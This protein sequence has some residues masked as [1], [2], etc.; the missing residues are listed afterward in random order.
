MP[1]GDVRREQHISAVSAES[2]A[3]VHILHIEEVA[4]VEAADG[5]EIRTPH[6]HAGAA[7]ARDRLEPGWQRRASQVVARSRKDQAEPEPP[8]DRGERGQFHLAATGLLPPLAIKHARADEEWCAPSRGMGQETRQAI[9]RKDAVRVDEQQELTARLQGTEVARR[10]EADV[11][12][13][14]QHA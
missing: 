1:E 8:A 12:V 6:E 5:P 7:G 2:Q 11:A 4:L 10:A 14:G 13:P 3:E 9:R